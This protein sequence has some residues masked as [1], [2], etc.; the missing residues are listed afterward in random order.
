MR[1]GH[2]AKK[3]VL[4]DLQ[5]FRLGSIDAK[6]NIFLKKKQGAIKRSTNKNLERLSLKALTT[7]HGPIT[8]VTEADAARYERREAEKRGGGQEGHEG[9]RDSGG[10][11]GPHGPEPD[12]HHGPHWHHDPDGQDEQTWSADWRSG[13][14]DPRGPRG[15]RAQRPSAACRVNLSAAFEAV[16]ADRRAEVEADWSAAAATALRLDS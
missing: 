12:W 15:P 8:S 9:H 14:R 11:D 4:A 13:P 3:R 10:H 5:I 16:E 7:M 2:L 6:K 1:I